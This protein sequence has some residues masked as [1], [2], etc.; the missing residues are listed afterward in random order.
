[1]GY[2]ISIDPGA[3]TGLCPWLNQR[4]VNSK[5]DTIRPKGG[6]IADQILDLVDQLDDYF[7]GYAT[8]DTIDCVAV[9]DFPIYHSVDKDPKRLWATKKAMKVCA[10]YQGAIIAVAKNYATRVIVQSKGRIKKSETALLAKAY[11]LKG[12]KDALDAFQIGVCAGFD[13]KAI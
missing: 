4:P 5:L 13:R 6:T 8:Q 2:N 9:E 7:M 11:G 1:M 10:A 3:N 12:S